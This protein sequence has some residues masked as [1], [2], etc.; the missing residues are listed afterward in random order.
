MARLIYSA[1]TSVDGFIEDEAGKFGWAEPDEEVH[2]FFNDLERS[3]GTHL[4]GRGMYETMKVWDSMADDPSLPE[5]VLDFA[6]A[7]MANDKIVYSRTLEQVNTVRTRIEREFEADA[8]RRLKDDS[9][10]DLAVGGAGIASAA[11]A[12]ELVDDVFLFLAPVIVGGGKQALPSGV[13]LDLELVDQ[14][15]FSGSMVFLH[16]RAREG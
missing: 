14:R 15:G 5:Y 3:V 9:E 13:H 12:A 1:I 4:F 2:R 16:Y 11:F 6:Q 10:H 7:W 8:V